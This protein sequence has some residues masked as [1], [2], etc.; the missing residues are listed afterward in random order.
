[1]EAF[2]VIGKR[3]NATGK[4]VA[5]K[6]RKQGLIPGIVYGGS[7]PIPVI[8]DP[9]HLVKILR[10]PS[11]ENTIF[12]FTVEGE[13]Q[14]ERKVII[15][16]LQYHPYKELLLH[17]DLHEISM[18]EEIVVRVPIELIGEPIGVRNGGVLSH[19][20]WEVEVECLPSRIPPK[21]EV[22]VSSLD[23][24]DVLYVSDLQIPVGV[25]VLQEPEEAVAS[26][27]VITEEV[28][29]EAPEEE[30]ITEPERIGR[31]REEEETEED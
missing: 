22:D 18:D 6:I 4:G 12:Q 9:K 14:R 8:V 7:A 11:G 15:R 28:I 19:L 5:R 10:S 13:E 20:L 2:T 30:E 24:G 21:I 23:I 27:S 1:M 25:K 31:G 17:V 3:R 26:V 16:D 29:E